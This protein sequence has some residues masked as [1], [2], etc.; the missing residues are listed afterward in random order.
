MVFENPCIWPGGPYVYVHESAIGLNN[1]TSWENAFT[2]LQDAIYTANRYGNIEE[3]WVAEGTYRPHTTDRTASF[4]LTDSIRIYGGFLG[5][6]TDR[7][8]RTS[9]PALVLIS[10]DIN[11]ADTLTDNSFHIVMIDE[12]CID[13]RLDGLTIQYGHADSP[14]DSHNRGAGIMAFG[15]LHLNNVVFERNYAA[16]LGAAL[17]ISGVNA[18][19][20]V[21]N[22][23]FQ[24]NNSSLYR[25]VV[26]VDGS[27]ITFTGANVLK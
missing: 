25:D 6:E 1:G 27:T 17:F 12:Q 3:I 22:C 26:S 13:C 23:V 2:D 15:K 5:F 18:D 20:G 16:D 4:V 7:E 11:E 8:E 14:I 10:G 19:V 9:D 24:L 21:H